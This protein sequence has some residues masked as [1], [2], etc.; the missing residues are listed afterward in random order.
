MTIASFPLEV[1]LL[2]PGF[3]FI[4]AV[5]LVS[6]FRKLSVFQG[7]AWSLIV[8]LI[9]V[10]T[11]YPAYTLLVKASP[12]QMW[13]GLLEVVAN[14]ALVPGPVWASLYVAAPLFGIL[15]GVAERTG[16]FEKVLRPVGID[17]RLHGDLW[18][19]LFRDSGYVQVQVYLRDGNLLYGWPEYYS[20]DRSQPGPELYLTQVGIWDLEGST[21]VEMS[22]V[23]GVLI[24]ASQI[25][26]IEFL[27]PADDSQS[28]E[29]VQ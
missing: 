4:N 26:R 13:P 1:F 20:S 12:S 18:G 10:V 11:I 15:A 16:L 7:T 29:I 24:D 2:L 3:L 25:S 9:L 21:W 27:Q 22:N 14:P 5:F 28:T 6:R 17:L 19:R 23:L 8:S